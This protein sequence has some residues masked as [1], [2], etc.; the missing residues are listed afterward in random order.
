MCVAQEELFWRSTV[1][2]SSQGSAVLQQSIPT[3]K[4]YHH[5]RCTCSEQHRKLFPLRKDITICTALALNSTAS[6]VV[7]H[8]L[9]HVLCVVS[10]KVC[11]STGPKACCNVRYHSDPAYRPERIDCITQRMRESLA[12]F[13]NKWYYEGWSSTPPPCMYSKTCYRI[14]R[15][16]PNCRSMPIRIVA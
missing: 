14:F 8:V 1:R 6:S 7:R 2:C 13:I 9:W 5:L 11:T 3:P 15:Y 4:S 16:I 12:E 10:R